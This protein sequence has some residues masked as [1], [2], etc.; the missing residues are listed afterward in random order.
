MS[1]RGLALLGR[2]RSGRVLPA[3]DLRLRKPELAE[4]QGTHGAVPDGSPLN[5]AELGRQPLAELAGQD[6]HVHEDRQ[7]HHPESAQDINHQ[8]A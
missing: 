1:R 4:L 8:V 5:L 2:S 3:F 7:E 6:E